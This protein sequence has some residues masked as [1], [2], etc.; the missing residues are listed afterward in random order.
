MSVGVAT[1]RTAMD[2]TGQ[3]GT[4]GRGA[5][6]MLVLV[7]LLTSCGSS[8][9][10]TS[11][12]PDADSS[13][14]RSGGSSS[15]ATPP[16]DITPP[17]DFGE[18]GDPSTWTRQEPGA[19]FD[20]FLGGLSTP[21]GGDPCAGVESNQ[22]EVRSAGKSL[23]GN[24]VQKTETITEPP[25][26]GTRVGL[27][28]AASE[29]GQ[30]LAVCL[31]DNATSRLSV[32]NP[33]RA[34]ELMDLLDGR[35]RRHVFLRPFEIGEWMIS[36]LV[37]EDDIYDQPLD[38]RVPDRAVTI[39]RLPGHQ[40]LIV[41]EPGSSHQLGLGIAAANGIFEFLT[42]LEPVTVGADGFTTRELALDPDNAYCVT[43]PDLPGCIQ[44]SVVGG[45]PK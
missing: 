15:T 6:G 23:P 11:G 35:S 36:F 30:L 29:Q 39:R 40:V 28:R 5:L 10:V 27:S 9:A 37:G 16:T 20:G 33:S 14:A 43:G 4:I 19:G 26:P 1:L 42:L 22:F 3:V 21:A 7:A 2:S 24:L 31:P 25:T 38:V 44:L 41:G 45:P 17:G 34:Q 32:V 12:G 13:A 8:N 18:W